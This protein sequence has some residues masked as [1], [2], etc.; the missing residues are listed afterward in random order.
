MTD[1]EL[2]IWLRVEDTNLT[3]F[4]AARIEALIAERNDWESHAIY[5]AEFV[6][7]AFSYR[8][9]RNAARA[10]LE[11]LRQALLWCSG[12]ADFNE[13]GVAREGWLKVCAP[14]LKGESHDPL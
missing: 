10:K 9:E 8:N 13:G 11:E 6:D 1:E 12:S 14:L 4:A 3:D 7:L 2:L 5:N